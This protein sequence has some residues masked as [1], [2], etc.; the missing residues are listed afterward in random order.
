MITGVALLGAVAGVGWKPSDA[1]EPTGGTD[2][3]TSL[4]AVTA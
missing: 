4:G 1:A 3:F 2:G